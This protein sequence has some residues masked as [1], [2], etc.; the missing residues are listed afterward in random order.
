M[1]EAFKQLVGVKNFLE[2][3]FNENTFK[4]HGIKL[5]TSENLLTN[6]DHIKY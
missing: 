1:F 3:D 2:L 4:K 6:K 5:G